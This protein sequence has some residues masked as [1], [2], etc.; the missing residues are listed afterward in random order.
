MKLL[1]GKLSQPSLTISIFKTKFV[2]YSQSAPLRNLRMKIDLK[3]I[4]FSIIPIIAF[5]LIILALSPVLSA[6]FFC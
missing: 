4:T 5:G 1:D 3:K 2:Q 6:D